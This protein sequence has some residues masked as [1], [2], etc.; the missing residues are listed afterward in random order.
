VETDDEVPDCGIK[1][2]V[3]GTG[4]LTGLVTGQRSGSPCGGARKTL[5]PKKKI[6]K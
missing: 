6:T 5:K 3:L 2:A 4:K 1:S